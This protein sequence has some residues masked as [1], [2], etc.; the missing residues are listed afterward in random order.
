MAG[1]VGSDERARGLIK[2]AASVAPGSDWRFYDTAY[3]GDRS[4]QASLL[5]AQS[6]V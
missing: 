1:M 4:K 2:M 6:C 5:E 3:T